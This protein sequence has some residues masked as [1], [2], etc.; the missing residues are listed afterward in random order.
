MKEKQQHPVSQKVGLFTPV[1]PLFDKMGGWIKKLSKALKNIDPTNKDSTIRDE[2]S[3]F[4]NSVRQPLWEL[5]AWFDFPDDVAAA[6][7][8]YIV[9][10]DKQAKDKYKPLPPWLRMVLDDLDAYPIEI[11]NIFYAEGIDTKHGNSITIGAIIYFPRAINLDDKINHSREDLCTMLH[12]LEH[13]VQYKRE[14]G[15]GALLHKYFLQPLV[16]AVAHGS[17][18]INIHGNEELEKDAEN[19]ASGLI[20]RVTVAANDIPVEYPAAVVV[21]STAGGGG[22]GDRPSTSGRAMETE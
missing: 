3:R 15:V 2:A 1:I 18:A 11:N 19:K 10:L 6:T 7:R 13:V 12:V 5:S 4:S 14:G 16:S 22:G 21:N 8:A 17:S 20:E 9:D